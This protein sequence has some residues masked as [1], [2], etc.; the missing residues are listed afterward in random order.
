[1]LSRKDSIYNLLK[2]MMYHTFIGFGIG[3][4]MYEP[5]N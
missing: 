4:K 1:M 3:V 2:Y 5:S